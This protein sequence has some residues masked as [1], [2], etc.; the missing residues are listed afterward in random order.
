MNRNGIR[1]GGRPVLAPG[2][3]AYISINMP[4]PKEWSP[5]EIEAFM[6]RI[7]AFQVA[8]EKAKMTRK[9]P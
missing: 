3:K 6:D 4:Q 2:E 1:V 9:V 8:V 7:K 5:D